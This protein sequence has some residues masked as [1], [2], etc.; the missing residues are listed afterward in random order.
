M[1]NNTNFIKY[2]IKKIVKVI[3]V[4]NDLD[5]NA[6]FTDWYL[7]EKVYLDNAIIQ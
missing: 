7:V 2:I 4:K 3:W 5:I 6:P 1:E